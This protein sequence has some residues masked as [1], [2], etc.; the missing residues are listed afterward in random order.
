[1]KKLLHI[2]RKR[3]NP[4]V[5]TPVFIEALEKIGEVEI[6]SDGAEMS[7]EACAER[8]Q[9]CH[10]LLTSWDARPV[11]VSIVGD[12]GSLEYICHVTGEM[13]RFIPVELIDSGIPVTN[14]GDAPAGRIAEGAVA[15]LLAMVKNLRARIRTVEKGGWRTEDGVYSGTL[16]GMI[17]GVYGCGFIGRRFVEMLRPFDPVIRVYDPY[18]EDVPEGCTRVTSL[19][20][21]FEGAEAIAIHAGQTDETRGTVTAELLARLPDHGIV[22]NTARGGIIDQDALF[23]ELEQGRLLAA[24]DV[25]EPD[26]PLPED[27]PARGWPNLILSAHSIG[28]AQSDTVV[29][30]R[31]TPMHRVC[32]EN[33]RRHVNGEALEFTMDRERYLLST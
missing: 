26:G 13:R 9:G 8:I 6:V 3:P 14:W 11:P 27:H 21:L 22:V 30:D 17:I 23:T 16:D 28:K 31:L 19:E 5:W 10:V 7:D 29:S 15:L 18:T 32:L 12:G 2:A 24:L 1:M 20:A 33:L 25:L 4:R